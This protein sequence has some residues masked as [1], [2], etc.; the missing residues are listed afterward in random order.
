MKRRVSTK[1]KRFTLMQRYPACNAVL[2]EKATSSTKGKAQIINYYLL[3]PNIMT[4]KAF[5]NM[6]TCNK[7]PGDVLPSLQTK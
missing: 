4:T 6:E 1:S 3:M 7:G 2:T 5:I